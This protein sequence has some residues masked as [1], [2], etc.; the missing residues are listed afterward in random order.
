MEKIIIVII[1]AKIACLKEHILSLTLRFDNKSIYILSQPHK[2][3]A[4]DICP[5]TRAQ[6][7][8]FPWRGEVT[9]LLFK[10]SHSECSTAFSRRLNVTLTSSLLPATAFGNSSTS[11]KWAISEVAIATYCTQKTAPWCELLLRSFSFKYQPATSHLYLQRYFTTVGAENTLLPNQILSLAC[12]LVPGELLC[13]CV[14][15]HEHPCVC[16]C[17]AAGG[18]SSWTHQQPC[19]R[20][21]WASVWSGGHSQ[22]RPPSSSWLA[23][24]GE[25]A[26]ALLHTPCPVISL[27]QFTL[28]IVATAGPQIGVSHL[29]FLLHGV[30]RDALE[31]WASVLL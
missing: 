7:W 11:L 19:R 17:G 1:I 26:Y 16:V 6:H 10:M 15:G 21:N 3:I 30:H 25:G 22:P 2:I 12:S 8:V 20:A 13:P 9:A 18:R 23:P 27:P 28:P 29:F 31:K 5:L 24:G 14:P 4:T